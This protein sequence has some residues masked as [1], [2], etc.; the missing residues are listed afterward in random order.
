[1]ICIF[2][3]KHKLQIQI[4][5]FVIM[6]TLFNDTISHTTLIA[7]DKK[8]MANYILLTKRER[9]CLLPLLDSQTLAGSD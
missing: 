8:L 3:S 1:M 7:S 4:F 2:R 5:H 9:N 6:F